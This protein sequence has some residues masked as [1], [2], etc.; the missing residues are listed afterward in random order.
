[1]ADTFD[2]A[3]VTVSFNGILLYG[4]APGEFLTIERDENMF[5]KVIGAAGEGA[6]AKTNNK[7][8]MVTLR[9]LQTS[10]AND[11]LSALALADEN[12]N[13]GS[14]VLMIRDN[15]GTL[16]CVC[17]DAWIQKLPTINFG[18]EITTKEW[19]FECVNIQYNGGSN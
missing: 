1:M 12:L 9:L 3:Q 2:A 8:G 17:D 15:S 11:L 10:D 13:T 16:I 14:G 6:R 4:Y 18:T 5:N 7:G 19:V